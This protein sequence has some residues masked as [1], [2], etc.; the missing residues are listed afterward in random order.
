[1]PRR[2]IFT[3]VSANYIG[4]AATL[5]QSVRAFHPD[6]ARYI[7]LA[8]APRAFPDVDLAAELIGC[9]DLGIPLIENMKLWYSVIEFNTAIKP[10]VFR[11]L[12]GPR[13]CTQVVYLDPDILLFAPLE[14]VFAALAENTLVLTPHMMQPLQD[15]RE[16][17]DL[18][19]LRSGV[20]NLGFLALRRDADAERLVGWWSERCFAHCRV[21]VAANLFTD[22]RWMD[23]AP[24]FVPR[25]FILRHTGYNVAYW[26]IAHRRVAKQGEG[27]TVDGAPLVFFHFSGIEPGKPEVF[28]KHQN[29]FDATNLPPAI[30]ELCADYRELVAANR[31]AAYKPVPY[32]F[33]NFGNGRPIEEFMRRWI[34][35]AVDDERLDPARPLGIGSEF[36]DE[37]DEVA[38]ARGVVMTRFMYQFWLDRKDLQQVFDVYDATGLENYLAWFLGG[39]AEAQGVDGRSV[40]AAAMLY[41]SDRTESSSARARQHPWPSVSATSWDGTA[42]EVGGFLAGDVLARPGGFEMLL[43]RQAALAWELRADLQTYFPVGDPDALSEY[44]AWAITSGALER[45]VDPALFSDRFVTAMAA[46][47]NISSYY[48]DVPLTE[49]MLVTRKIPLRREYLDGWLRFP[50]ERSGRMAHALWYAYVATKAYGWPAAM[51]A[52]VR[53]YFDEP[54]DKICGGFRLS[55]GALALWE[56][57]TDVQRSFPLKDEASCWAF[58]FWLVTDGLRELGLALD[59]FDPRLRPFL[60]DASLRLAGVPNVLELVHAARTDLQAAFDLRE[61]AGRAALLDWGRHHFGPTYSTTPLAAAHPFPPPATPAAPAP[62]VHRAALGLTGQWSLPS[63]RGEDLRCNARALQ[64]AGCTDFLIIDRGTGQVLRPDGTA[65][66][67]GPVALDINIV[68][69]NAD[70]AYDDWNFL[71][72]AQVEARRSI[73]FWAWELDRLPRRWL[74]SFAF[75]DEIWAATEFARGAFA[76]EALRPVELVPMAVVAPPAGAALD[77]ARLGLPP[78]ATVFFFMFDF[79][80]YASRKNPEAVVRAFLR[81]FPDG[82]E[83]VHLLIKTQGGAAAAGPWR[84]LNGLCR[85]PRIEIRDVELDRADLIALIEASDAF[86]SL[87]R[88]EGFGRGPA[89]AMLMGKPVILTGYSGTADFATPECAYVVGYRMVAV[90]DNEYP[91]AE[92]QE[93]AD[94]DLDEAAVHMRHVHERPDDARALGARGR[95]AIMRRYEPRTVGAHM[96]AVL[97]LSG[98]TVADPEEGGRVVRLRRGAGRPKLMEP[99]APAR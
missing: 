79:R 73:G 60:A 97:G 42:A 29:R 86:V 45:S 84:R 10:Y 80:S 89:E 61:E 76:R 48:R 21:D 7:V 11:H 33:A 32:G 22:Q 63:G 28:S 25:S 70:T 82:R 2:A 5:M 74:H 44:L 66:P 54:T 56:L 14:E 19:I 17:S 72:E 41:D 81:A 8:D 52:P 38:A 6:V 35:R 57:R 34:L 49:G 96:L 1:M 77:R 53:R 78:D 93:W 83:K 31:F 20:Y 43:P 23:L 68:H 59:E 40:A 85:D 69:L 16:P 75:Y 39:D 51:A 27:W 64:E 98:E 58:L 26:N 46:L 62:A 55:R 67:P 94:A 50:T 87:H 9:D 65:L 90:G 71:R 37:A 99:A 47:S 15:G 88:S 95:A 92:G 4:Y 3:I 12:F 91:G 30:A 24:A 13:D 36:F 18:T